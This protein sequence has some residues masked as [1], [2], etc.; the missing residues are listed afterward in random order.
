MKLYM[1]KAAGYLK[2][3]G[4][5]EFAKKVY[6]KIYKQTK[7]EIYYQNWIK[8]HIPGEEELEKQRRKKFDWMPLFSIVV[9]LYNT[10]EKYLKELIASVQ[11]QSYEKWELLLSDGSGRPSPLENLLKEYQQDS[12]I[13]IFGAEEKLN[14]SENTNRIM[15]AAKGDYIVFADHDDLL[16]PNALY[17]CA[18]A[19]VEENQPDMI[20]SDEDKVTMDGRKYFLPHFKPDFNLDL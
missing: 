6:R 18:K 16:T 4:C 1:N 20:Y 17:E 11:V 2:K 8:D 5:R 13:R 12:R 10:P 19:I 9:P 7:D 3:N 15:S 14:I